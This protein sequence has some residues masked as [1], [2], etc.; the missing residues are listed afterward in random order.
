MAKKKDDCDWCGPLVGGLCFAWLFG[1]MA[2][3]FALHLF[4]GWTSNEVF[5]LMIPW[6]LFVL[7]SFLAL[8][9]LFS[10]LWGIKE[11]L[12]S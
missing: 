10:L 8:F 6:T 12:K 3:S 2:I 1:G 11:A 7:C 9:G 4:Y 5:D